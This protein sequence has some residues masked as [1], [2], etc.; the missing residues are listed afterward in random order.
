MYLISQEVDILSSGDL[1]ISVWC[2][3]YPG[4]ITTCPCLPSILSLTGTSLQGYVL[5]VA[6]NPVFSICK[7]PCS[8]KNLG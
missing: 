5:L 4:N 7:S 1:L 8:G 3:K 6:F 2:F